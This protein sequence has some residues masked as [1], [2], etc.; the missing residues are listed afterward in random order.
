MFSGRNQSLWYLVHGRLKRQDSL[1]RGSARFCD[2]RGGSGTSGTQFTSAI[3][4]AATANSASAAAPTSP[5]APNNSMA[6]NASDTANGYTTT[7][8]RALSQRRSVRLMPDP[9]YA[10]AF[11]KTHAT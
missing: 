8:G 11:F 7:S 3:A 9:R 2:S 1:C 6:E 5:T 10:T 4:A